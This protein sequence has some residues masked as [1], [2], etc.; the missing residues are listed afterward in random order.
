VGCRGAQR[1]REPSDAASSD[2]DGRSSGAGLNCGRMFSQLL[3][4]MG[5]VGKGR[6]GVG[7]DIVDWWACEAVSQEEEQEPS[8]G[9]GSA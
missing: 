9:C 8:L 7:T 6:V 5:E 2:T 1:W 4:A 3:R